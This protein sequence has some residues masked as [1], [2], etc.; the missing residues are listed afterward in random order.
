[1]KLPFH[2]VLYPPTEPTTDG[3][4]FHSWT[5]SENIRDR[6]LD[7]G[8]T[9]GEPDERLRMIRESQAE[10]RDEM[11]ELRFWWLSRMKET[12]SPLRR[13]DDTLLA[14]PFCDQRSKGTKRL[15]D[16]ASKRNFPT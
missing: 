12:A 6:R 9:G 8:K 4:D 16:V 2:H 11:A 3:D 5:I 1:L 14:R 10:Q 7:L 15:L 13:E